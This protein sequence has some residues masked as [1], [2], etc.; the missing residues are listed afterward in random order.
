M[1]QVFPNPPP[2]LRA[3]LLDGLD[4]AWPQ[5]GRVGA[6]LTGAERLAV[7]AAARAAWD[8]A[9]CAERKAALSP[10]AIDGDHDGDGRLPDAWLDAVHRVVTDSGRLTERWLQGLLADG[11]LED[12]FV[13]L[14]SVAVLVT[15]VD[16]FMRAIGR[17]PLPL[18]DAAGGVP[19]RRRR[20]DAKPGPGWVATIAPEDALLDFVD[21]YAGG[22]HFYIRRALTLLPDEVQRL[23]YL[24]NRLYMPDPRVHEFDGLERSISRAQAEY[25]AAR[26]SAL[27]GCYY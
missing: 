3:D 1:T 6:W 17:D 27:L 12:E 7:A 20:P 24:L 10:Y 18:P 26:A 8:C 9:L 5:I 13:E 4:T 2:E 19:H 11:L 25:L 15:T 16:T 14:V 23:W 21:Y 22:S